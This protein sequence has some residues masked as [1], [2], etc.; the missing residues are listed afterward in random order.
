MNEATVSMSLWFQCSTA[1]STGVQKL[2]HKVQLY[3][4]RRRTG[5]NGKP[6]G[7][8]RDPSGA[9]PFSGGLTSRPKFDNLFFF[10]DPAM[11]DYTLADNSPASALGIE[12]ID[13]AIGPRGNVVST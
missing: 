10:R 4:R 3:S 2:E 8:T 9:S 7:M 5:C 11:K 6:V 1:T 13:M 12:E